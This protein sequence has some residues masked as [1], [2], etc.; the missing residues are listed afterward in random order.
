MKLHFID[1][2]IWF[3]HY[4]VNRREPQARRASASGR[5]RSVF[6][7][8][9]RLTTLDTGLKAVSVFQN[10][11]IKPLFTDQIEIGSFKI[12]VYYSHCGLSEVKSFRQLG[13]NQCKKLN[14]QL[15][16]L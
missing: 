12:S 7:S 16:A 15:Y 4:R 11:P 1:T 13:V 10:L 2:D 5:R 8:S 9:V 3:S 6:P 14:Y